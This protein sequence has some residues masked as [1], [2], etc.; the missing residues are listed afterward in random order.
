MVMKLFLLIGLVLIGASAQAQQVI[1][2]ANVELDNGADY[3]NISSYYQVTFNFNK[4]L[5]RA[6][7][8]VNENANISGHTHVPNISGRWNVNGLRYD[9]ASKNIYYGNIVV[10]EV[11]PGLFGIGYYVHNTGADLQLNIV[12]ETVDDS[13]NT[14]QVP[15][16]VVT[17]VL[18]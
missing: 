7:V 2:V 8:E 13:F 12:E 18:K 4:S 16:E 9:D 6:W 11:K 14:Y 15:F 17:M 10:A 3:Y 1:P 5:S